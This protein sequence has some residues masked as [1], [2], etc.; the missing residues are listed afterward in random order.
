MHGSIPIEL[1]FLPSIHPRRRLTVLVQDLGR[2]RRLVM[3]VANSRLLPVLVAVVI[4]I[5]VHQIH[6]HAVVTISLIPNTDTNGIII[7]RTGAVTV[8]IAPDPG[9]KHLLGSAPPGVGSG[10]DLQQPRLARLGREMGV[11]L[12]VV[13]RAPEEALLEIVR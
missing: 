11:E 4:V 9:T 3:M 12:V 8:P 2:I 10:Q 5:L 7:P 1:R 13:K 6:K